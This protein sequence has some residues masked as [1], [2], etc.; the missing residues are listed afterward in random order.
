MTK[1]L[2]NNRHTTLSGCQ[3]IIIWVQPWNKIF[4]ATDFR[5]TVKWK[6]MW[7]TTARRT[8]L[9]LISRGYTKSGPMKVINAPIVVGTMWKSGWRAVQVN[10]N[11]SHY[12]WNWRTQDRG[13]P[14]STLILWLNT[15]MH[16]SLAKLYPSVFIALTRLF[17]T[18]CKLPWFRHRHKKSIIV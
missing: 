11:C 15:D 17:R 6:Q 18:K 16:T 7:Y 13:R 1:E 8:G 3:A 5:M 14:C 10:I 2:W 9:G 12:S 4:M